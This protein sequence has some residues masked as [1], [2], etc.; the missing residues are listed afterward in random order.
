MYRL[1]VLEARGPRLRC[2]QGRAPSEASRGEDPSLPPPGSWGGAGRCR[3]SLAFRGLKVHHSILRL[4][5]ALCVHLCVHMSH[6]HDTV[7]LD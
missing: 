2:R 4:H 3:Q 1:P 7:I 5:V 6:F